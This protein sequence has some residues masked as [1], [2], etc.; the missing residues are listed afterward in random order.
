MNENLTIVIVTG[1]VLGIPLVGITARM[2]I[3]PLV[4]ALV[5]LR[6]AGVTTGAQQQILTDR[7]MTE[8]QE[9]VASLRQ[10]VERLMEAESFN[11]QLGAGQKTSEKLGP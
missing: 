5:R 7:R 2:V 3:K 4:E 8:L 10:N 6:E 11:R 1:I 9:E